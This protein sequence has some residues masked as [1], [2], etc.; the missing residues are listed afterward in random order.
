M[1]KLLLLLL[2]VGPVFGQAETINFPAPIYWDANTETDVVD[3]GVY[4]SDTPC[5]DPNPSPVTCLSFVQQA[6]VVQGTDPRQWTE[7]GPIIFVQDYYYRITARNTSGHESLFSNELNL[8]WLN[9]N[10]PGAPG[11]LRAEE[12]GANMWL[13]WDDDAHVAAWRIYKSVTEEERGDLVGV[14][15]YSDHRDNN[16]GRVGPRYYR[17]T[18]V[19]AAGEEGEAAGP[20]IYVGK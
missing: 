1:R 13:D 14:T 9:P 15:F 17:V 4:R 7:P 6:A 5:T 2:F 18:G 11:D 19:N 8:R 10:A 12:Q 16:P 3:Y 20:V